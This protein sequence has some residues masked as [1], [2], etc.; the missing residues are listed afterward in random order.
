MDERSGY[1]V[2][3]RMQFV[4]LQSGCIGEDA[5][6]NVVSSIHWEFNRVGNNVQ[7]LYCLNTPRTTSL[8][9]AD[10]AS[11]TFFLGVPQRKHKV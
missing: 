9:Q 11:S 7:I 4:A 5:S 1:E 6:N 8:R 10:V 2:S 3:F